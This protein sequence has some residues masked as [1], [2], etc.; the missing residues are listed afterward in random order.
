MRR[1]GPKHGYNKYIHSRNNLVLVQRMQGGIHAV[2]GTWCAQSRGTAAG[3]G[4]G[5]R[6]HVDAAL[7]LL[8]QIKLHQFSCDWLKEFN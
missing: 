7:S 1:N 8:L 5:L 2:R 6:V 3:A 4:R